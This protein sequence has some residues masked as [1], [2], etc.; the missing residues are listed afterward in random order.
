[1]NERVNACTTERAN[2]TGVAVYPSFLY[3]LMRP[4]TTLP[5]TAAAASDQ[6]CAAACNGQVPILEI[7]QLLRL[8]K[9]KFSL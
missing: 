4:K 1:M 9:S 6:S 3:P 2:A 5:Q 7:S 8:K